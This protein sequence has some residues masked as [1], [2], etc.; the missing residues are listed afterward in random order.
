MPRR[1]RDLE[2]SYT[3]SQFAAKLRR[4][5]DAVERERAFPIM[6]AGE[7]LYVPPGAVFN[8]E[9]ERSGR[10]EELEFQVRWTVPAAVGPAKRKTAR[11]K[12]S[13]GKSSSR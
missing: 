9:H 3:A 13:R 7:R 8:V 11:R 12:G 2:K 4:F 5:A 10:E 1:N 6:V